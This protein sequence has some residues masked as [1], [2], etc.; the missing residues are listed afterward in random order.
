MNIDSNPREQT[1]FDSHT[2]D[3]ISMIWSSDRKTMFTGEMGA[4]PAIHQWNASGEL[5]KTYKG[6]KKGVSALAVND[7]YLAGSGLDDDHY[8]YVFD[9]RS[10]ALIAS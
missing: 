2:D 1:F 9:V 10:G 5:I 7:K 3:I 4:K 6:V 8:I